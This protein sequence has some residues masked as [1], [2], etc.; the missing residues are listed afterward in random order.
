MVYF[1]TFLGQNGSTLEFGNSI[2]IF[3]NFFENSMT[4]QVL[5]SVLFLKSIPIF[6][7]VFFTLQS[8]KLPETEHR[9]L[10]HSLYLISIKII[11]HMNL[12][13]NS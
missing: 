10:H 12:L 11:I 3:G 5:R 13:N 2:S 7:L 6:C 4:F 8:M 1:V 9:Q